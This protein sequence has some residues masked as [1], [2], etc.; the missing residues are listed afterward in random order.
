MSWVKAGLE[1]RVYV[2]GGLDLCGEGSGRYLSCED[3]CRLRFGRG[4]GLQGEEGKDGM[5]LLTN[6]TWERIVVR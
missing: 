1:I 3:L 4:W 2:C 5:G 6:Y